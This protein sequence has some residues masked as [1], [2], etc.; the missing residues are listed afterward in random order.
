MKLVKLFKNVQLYYSLP[1]YAILICPFLIMLIGCRLISEPEDIITGFYFFIPL[2]I[3]FSLLSAVFSAFY[4]T[5]NNDMIAASN[6]VSFRTRA[7]NLLI[8]SVI[9]SVL[10]SGL[11]IL[12]AGLIEMY[13]NGQGLK[14]NDAYKKF[15]LSSMVNNC[16]FV[17]S[18]KLKNFLSGAIVYELVFVCGAALHYIMKGAAKLRLKR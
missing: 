17:G 18:T 13:L 16:F 11:Y 12:S 4:I 14:G 8:C 1:M 15:M 5:S 9:I 2:L 6:N 7:L 10:A 3:I